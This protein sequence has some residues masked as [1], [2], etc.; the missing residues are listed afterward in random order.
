MRSLTTRVGHS[1]HQVGVKGAIHQT[2]GHYSTKIM[3]RGIDCCTSLLWLTI[4]RIKAVA[5]SEWALVLIIFF[6]YPMPYPYTGYDE[7]GRRW[8][9]E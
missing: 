4:A 2:L 5:G 9:V 8:D 1:S 7:G 3:D 6:V